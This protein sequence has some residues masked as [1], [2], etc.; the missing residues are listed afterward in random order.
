MSMTIVFC[1]HD[2][3]KLRCFQLFLINK[4]NQ[5]NFNLK[6]NFIFFFF[7]ENIFVDDFIFN[8]VIECRV[9]LFIGDIFELL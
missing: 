3:R 4:I 2:F 6:I 1:Y 5:M 7:K 8:I 9:L